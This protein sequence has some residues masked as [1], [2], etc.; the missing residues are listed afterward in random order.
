MKNRRRGKK[1]VSE[2]EMREKK[3]EEYYKKARKGKGRL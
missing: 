3:R 1:E 2:L